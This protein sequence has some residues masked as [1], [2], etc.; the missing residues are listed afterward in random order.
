MLYQKTT[1]MFIKSNLQNAILELWHISR[2]ALSN[3]EGVPSRYE[4][5]I[6]VR[7]N[8]SEHY[9]ELIDGLTVKNVWLTIGECITVV[10]Q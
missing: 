3:T 7:D 8:L 6:Y 2:T 5:M 4:R 1:T 9:K 10:P